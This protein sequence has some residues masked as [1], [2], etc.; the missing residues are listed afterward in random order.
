MLPLL[1]SPISPLPPPLLLLLRP[2]P[3]VVVLPPDTGLMGTSG[4]PTGGLPAWVITAADASAAAAAVTPTA[5]GISPVGRPRLGHTPSAAPTD[6]SGDKGGA[7]R[8]GSGWPAGGG[9]AAGSAVATVAEAA[10]GGRPRPAGAADQLL[11]GAPRAG[12]NG[13]RPTGPRRFLL[14]P[15]AG[16]PLSA[17][18]A[19]PPRLRARPESG[20]GGGGGD[21]E[22]GGG[23]NDGGT[24][25][26]LAPPPPPCHFPAATAGKGVHPGL[27]ATGSPMAAAALP[28][29]PRGSQ[30]SRRRSPPPSPPPPL[31]PSSVRPEPGGGGVANS[32][33]N[34]AALSISASRT[35][36]VGRPDDQAGLTEKGEARP[37]GGRA[38]GSVK[39]IR[40][41]VRPALSSPPPS[42]LPSLP[43]PPPSCP[44]V[45]GVAETAA[46]PAPLPTAG[47]GDAPHP[48]GA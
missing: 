33:S 18:G 3:S 7:N 38:D 13:I 14:A 9:S 26:G 37:A 32:L 42:P 27:C 1:P 5:A 34:H 21:G 10:G 12:G 35:M 46:R 28:L 19:D 2:L 23:G 30:P 41:G 44:G 36:A 8:D 40:T 20:G 29:P 16:A 39:D 15:P 47:E 6:G 22:G 4:P 48:E 31:P 11:R 24:A 17:C 45:G 43:P 25:A